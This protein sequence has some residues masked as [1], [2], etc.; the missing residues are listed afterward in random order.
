[1]QGVFMISV[2]KHSGSHWPASQS[3]STPAT[4]D[5]WLSGEPGY[6]QVSAWHT[7]H[8]LSAF[9]HVDVFENLLGNLPCYVVSALWVW[10]MGGFPAW[11]PVVGCRALVSVEAG[12]L[13]TEDC[14]SVFL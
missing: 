6:G 5:T 12:H 11:E 7:G 13:D 2:Q 8:V 10:T 4:Q 3:P 1:M 9:F 14:C